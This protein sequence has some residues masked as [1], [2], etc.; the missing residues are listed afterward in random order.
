MDITIPQKQTFKLKSEPS[1]S[2][3]VAE[4]AECFMNAAKS[5]HKL[6][7]KISGAGSYASHVALNEIYTAMPDF[8]DSLV[9][10]FQGASGEII[11][12][13]ETLAKELNSVKDAIMYLKE[14]KKEINLLQNKLPYSEI[15]NDLD[16]AKSAI[17]KTLYKL[18]FLQ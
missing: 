17:N 10:N 7:L 11:N 6:H 1:C 12:C 8:A 14:L 5:L 13:K 15:I 16:V 9:E 18:T 2:K 3:E 4:M